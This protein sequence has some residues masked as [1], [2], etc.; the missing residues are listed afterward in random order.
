VRRHFLFGTDVG[1][2]FGHRT[3]HQRYQKNETPDVLEQV[4]VPMA[5]ILAGSGEAVPIRTPPADVLVLTLDR[6][7]DTAVLVRVDKL[8]AAAS[9]AESA[10]DGARKIKQKAVEIDGQLVDKPKLAVPRPTRPLIARAGRSM[11]KVV[12][13]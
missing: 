1:A 8:L 7:L 3:L 11:K 6:G 13:A 10:S 12:I 9:L 5:R 4:T 2:F